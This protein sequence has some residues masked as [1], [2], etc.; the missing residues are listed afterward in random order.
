MAETT[1][2]LFKTELYRNPAVLADFG[3]H[4]KGLDDLEIATCGWGCWLNEG[5]VHSELGDLTPIEVEAEYYDRSQADAAR[6]NQTKESPSNPGRFGQMISYGGPYGGSPLSIADAEMPGPAG[7]LPTGP[8]GAS[9]ASTTYTYDPSGLLASE[10]AI[11]P[12]PPSP[13][14]PPS[15]SS[16]CIAGASDNQS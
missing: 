10:T 2:G 4:W 8:N 7:I 14:C 15:A 5:R 13:N 3:G 16:S 9:E 6:E 11:A 1:I 12:T